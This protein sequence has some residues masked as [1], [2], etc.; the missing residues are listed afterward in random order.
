MYRCVDSD[1]GVHMMLKQIGA[2]DVLSGFFQIF[3]FMETVYKLHE[4]YIILRIQFCAAVFF[5]SFFAEMYS[6]SV[7][8][9]MCRCVKVV[10]LQRGHTGGFQSLLQ[11]PTQHTASDRSPCGCR[12]VASGDVLQKEREMDR[13]NNRQKEKERERERQSLIISVLIFF[14]FICTNVLK[15]VESD[16]QVLLGRNET[17][18]FDTYSRLDKSGSDTH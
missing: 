10:Y 6:G 12:G 16:K 14:F 9:R 8:S 2:T 13:E 15:S 3:F 11:C 7:S 17:I 18:S 4:D 1:L 5:V